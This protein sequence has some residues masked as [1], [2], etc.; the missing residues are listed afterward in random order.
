LFQGKEGL[1]ITGFQNAGREMGRTGLNIEV[2]KIAAF[3]IQIHI[4][5]LPLTYFNISIIISHPL[6]HI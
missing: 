3:T 2:G 5:V 1:K 4:Y 6:S